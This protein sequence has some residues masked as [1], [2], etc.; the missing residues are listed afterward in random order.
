M[1]CTV[2]L[3]PGQTGKVLRGDMVFQIASFDGGRWSPRWLAHVGIAVSTIDDFYI[4]QAALIIHMGSYIEKTVWTGGLNPDELRVE[5]SGSIA[6]IDDLTRDDIVDRALSTYSFSSPSIFRSKGIA[7]CYWMGDPDPNAHPLYPNVQGLHAF[8]C[9]TYAHFC[10]SEVVGPIVD[11]DKIPFVTGDERR[12][13]EELLPRQYKIQSSRFKR[14]YP[15]YLI[16]ALSQ[17]D[18]PFSTDD[19]NSCKDHSVFIPSE[20]LT[21]EFA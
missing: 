15:S 1:P 16:H 18:I 7:N 13:L 8:S 2:F 14:L 4:G 20:L 5:V 9:A 3:P 17:N 19:W 21:Q 12:E 6:G 11:I 10:Y